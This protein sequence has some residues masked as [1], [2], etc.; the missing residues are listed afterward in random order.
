M[1]NPFKK[2]K[3]YKYVLIPDI[4]LYD[5]IEEDFIYWRVEKGTFLA[6]DMSG[7]NFDIY[8]VYGEQIKVNPQF[9]FNTEREAFSE[10][11][12][13]NRITQKRLLL[14]TI[15]NKEKIDKLEENLSKILKF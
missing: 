4:Y 2:K 6:H 13:K 1:K 7:A 8:S 5:R 3:D 14:C 9:V 10:S 15:S 12:R 11:N